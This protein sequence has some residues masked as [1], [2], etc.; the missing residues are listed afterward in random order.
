MVKLFRQHA[1][2]KSISGIVL[3]LILF[4]MIVLTIGFNIFTD[5]LLEQYAEGAYLTAK[6][7]SQYVNADEMENYL[8]S[9]GEGEEYQ[10]VWDNLDRLCNSSGST[11]IYVIIPDT[12]DYAHIKFIFSTIDHKS[13]FSKYDFG[14]LRE[15][16]N[17]EYRQKYR[18]LFEKTSEREIVVRDK[19]YIET[20]SHITL[21]VPL[22]DSEGN[23]RALLCVQRQMD[24]LTNMRQKFIRRALLAL[25]VL[26]VLV[27]LGQSVFLHRTLLHPLKLISDEATRFSTENTVSETKLRHSIRNEDE[28][29]M[30]AGS[31][32][33]MEEEIQVYIDNLTKATAE[34]ERIGAELS[35]ATKI[36]ASMLPNIYPAFPNRT[37]FDIYA[38]MT[39]AKEVGGDFYDFFLVDSD[40]LCMVMADVSGKGV[41]AALFMMA[42]KI[43]LANNAKMGKSPARILEDTNATICASNHE[44]MFVTVWL[45][46]LEISSGKLTAA[47]AGHEYPVIYMPDG[48]FELFKDKHGFVIGGM[49]GMKF[50]EYEVQLTQGAKLFVYTD[51]VPEATNDNNELFGTERMLAALNEDTGASPESVLQNVRT[52]VNCFVNNAEQFDDL[53][54][55]CMEYKGSETS[56]KTYELDVMA[57]NVNL[58]RVQAFLSQ[59]LE[60]VNCPAKAQMQMELA[61]EEIFVNIANYA[62]APDKGRALVRVEVSDEPVTVTMT[63]IDKGVPYDPLKRKEPDVTLPAEERE[64]G[65]LGIFLTKK[66]M[67]YVS[68]EYR[69]GQNILTLKKK[70]DE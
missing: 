47:N 52:A 19:G 2:V 12:T 35:L 30:L 20:D 43:I 28:I 5:A 10:Q 1:T 22:K 41:P 18:S 45:G 49:D 11:F 39:P 14:Y 9:N 62:Y 3:L 66:T 69:D 32:D 4:S 21:L 50:K 60:K 15:T 68:Y 70:I 58:S 37:E 27:L 40:H 65:G 24:V 7:A 55:L 36:Q 61:V 59:C 67:D 48:K 17:D 13:K 44:E 53:T 29:G 33:R 64:I 51:G 16:T 34:K 26:I 25:V 63:F 8:Q 38:T 57:E 42:S 46:I 31:I 54:M 23:V 6:T 56:L